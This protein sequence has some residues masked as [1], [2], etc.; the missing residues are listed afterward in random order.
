M[1]SFGIIVD[2]FNK[3]AESAQSLTLDAEVHN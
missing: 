1:I 2:Q 3:I